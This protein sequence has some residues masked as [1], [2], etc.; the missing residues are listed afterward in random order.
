MTKKEICVAFVYNY[1]F[2]SNIEKLERIYQDKFNN[3]FHLVP[4][5]DGD[6]E[7]VIPVYD[8][9]FCFQNFFAQAYRELSDERFSHYV[10]IAD[11]L[12]L[13]P[14]LNSS[15][16]I[17]ELNL[18]EN[19]GY[20]KHLD[21]LSSYSFHWSHFKKTLSNLFWA[22][23]DGQ[24]DYYFKQLPDKEEACAIFESYGMKMEDISWKHLRECNIGLL[25]SLHVENYNLSRKL[26]ATAFLFNH[27]RNRSLPYPF[28]A[29]YSDF[30]V[31]PA[32]AFKKFSHICGVFAAMNLWVE[33]ATP[34]A[35]ILSCEKVLT[36]K[37]ISWRGIE[38]WSPQEQVELVKKHDNDF[39]KILSSFEPHQLYTHPIK[40]SR[41]KT[42]EL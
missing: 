30:I 5:Y 18:S 2:D 26:Y 6:K 14:R 3:I 34:T 4:F 24:L 27:R 41:W 37:D 23:H 38:M 16:L 31:V 10:F 29:G 25:D 22:Q 32:S 17:D 42:S 19:S 9:S 21:A 12:I 28:A 8:Q 40:L 36:E 20:I 39:K 13:N 35:M 1:R 33:V 7:N 15:N 11:D